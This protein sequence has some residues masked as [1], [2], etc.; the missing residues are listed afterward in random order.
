MSS[1]KQHAP[2]AT[3]QA[4]DNPLLTAA[5]RYASRGWAVFPLVS[6]TKVPFKGTHGFKDVSMD[7]ATICA[8]WAKWLDANIGIATGEASNLT[9]LDTDPRNGAHLT[10][11]A[12]IAEH[13]VLPAT[14]TVITG[15]GGRHLYFNHT[16]T[17]ARGSNALG[18]GVDLKSDGGF[19]VAP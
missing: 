3:A 9:V 2:K 5:L 8:W 13:G 14:A 18:P 12:L 16:F 10:L 1:Q 6:R 4:K 17:L 11:D 7:P 19:I 15:S